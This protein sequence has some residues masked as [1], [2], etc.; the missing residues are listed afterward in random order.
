MFVAFALLTMNCNV[1]Q[2]KG[3]K[4]QSKKEQ[5]Q[6]NGKKDMAVDASILAAPLYGKTINVIGDSYVK[7]QENI[8]LGE[9]LNQ[10]IVII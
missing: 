2:A 6:A 3:E 10:M 8:W 5:K 4:Q 7:N 1:A 9:G